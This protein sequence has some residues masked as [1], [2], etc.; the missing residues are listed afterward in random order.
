L[1]GFSTDFGLVMALTMVSLLPGLI[2]IW[3]VR[4]YIARGFTV[5]RSN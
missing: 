5:G 3:F 4:H 2:M 1:F